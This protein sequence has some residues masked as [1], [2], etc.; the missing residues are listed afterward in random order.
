MTRRSHTSRSPG[1]EFYLKV[2]EC[3]PF[4]EW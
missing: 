1:R 4:D 2:T 3:E